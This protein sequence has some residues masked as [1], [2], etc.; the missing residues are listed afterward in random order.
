MAYKY[1]LREEEAE[2][3]ILKKRSKQGGGGSKTLP[4]EDK[5]IS[6]LLEAL[7]ENSRI[8]PEQSASFLH[9]ITEALE[10]SN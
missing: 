4:L 7:A 9:R 2:A 8:G 5:E 6:F 3:T 10:T 1:K